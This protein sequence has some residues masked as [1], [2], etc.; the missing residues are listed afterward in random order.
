VSASLADQIAD[1]A[2]R[3]SRHAEC[4]DRAAGD[5]VA[6]ADPLVRA[7][8]QAMAEAARAGSRLVKGMGGLGS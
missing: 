8:L 1:L 5:P 4:L 2:E 6:V 7:R 3:M